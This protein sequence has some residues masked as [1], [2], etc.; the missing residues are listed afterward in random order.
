MQNE[1]RQENRADAMLK[2]LMAEI[3]LKLMEDI[4]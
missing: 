2:K 3:F 1:R 4:R